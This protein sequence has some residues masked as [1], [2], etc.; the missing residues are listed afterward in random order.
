MPEEQSDTRTLYERLRE[1]REL[2]AAEIAE[3][4]AMRSRVRG[5]EQDEAGFL[6][7]VDSVKHQQHLRRQQEE[8]AVIKE[9]REKV[10]L[11]GCQPTG[12]S[13][14]VA[15]ADRRVGH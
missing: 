1:Q 2:K 8:E 15:E 4:K 6:D 12:K 13:F 11:A 10:D 3:E 9:L 7:L 14:P 5:L